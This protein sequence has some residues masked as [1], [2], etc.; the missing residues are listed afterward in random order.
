MVNM[1]NFSMIALE[2]LFSKQV[3]TCGLRASRFSDVKHC[4]YS[5]CRILKAC[6]CQNPMSHIRTKNTVCKRINFYY[7]KPNS[8]V[9][10]E[11]F[12]ECSGVI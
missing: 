9:D 3:I 11:V 4:S 2:G 5:L 12:S 6:L 7:F 8:I 1:E 10:Q